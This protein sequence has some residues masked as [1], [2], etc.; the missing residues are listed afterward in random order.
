MNVDEERYHSPLHKQSCPWPSSLWAQGP[1]SGCFQALFCRSSAEGPQIAVGFHLGVKEPSASLEVSGNHSL[2]SSPMH[3]SLC[4]LTLRKHN[5]SVKIPRLLPGS[6]CDYKHLMVGHWVLCGLTHSDTG[7]LIR[8]GI[9]MH[10]SQIE[11][12]R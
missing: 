2:W 6:L 4:A 1:T 7:L 9:F 12:L 10:G 11:P 3:S 8:A 5:V